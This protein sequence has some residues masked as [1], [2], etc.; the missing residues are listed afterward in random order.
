M[1]SEY[2]GALFIELFFFN[3]PFI[4][5]Q[6]KKENLAVLVQQHEYAF[7]DG[8][9]Y[10]SLCPAKSVH[11]TSKILISQRLFIY[12]LHSLLIAIF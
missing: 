8:T 4:E 9:T 10:Y 7:H 3:E 6:G 11:L 12:S 2:Q 1:N 5:L